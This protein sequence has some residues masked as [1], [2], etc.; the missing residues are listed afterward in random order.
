MKYW[1]FLIGQNCKQAN[2]TNSCFIKIKSTI[3]DIC[4]SKIRRIK[5]KLTRIASSDVININRVYI[6]CTN[7]ILA[8]WKVQI[9]LRYLRFHWNFYLLVDN[10]A[11]KVVRNKLNLKKK[12][13]FTFV[14]IHAATDSIIW[15]SKV[16]YAYWIFIAIHSCGPNYIYLMKMNYCICK[17][18]LYMTAGLM[19]MLGVQSS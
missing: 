12:T 16:R 17:L 9:L 2:T 10:T 1:T 8:R 15:L 19:L 6:T 13:S 3:S 7:E 11:V 18:L 4:K 5:I 14:V